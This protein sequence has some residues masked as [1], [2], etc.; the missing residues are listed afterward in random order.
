M[1][2]S[3]GERI[4]DTFQFCHL[5]IPV[6]SITATDRIL[7]AM[8]RLTAAIEGIQEAPHDELAAIQTL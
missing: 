1:A 7:D 4:T 5:A 3:G 2:N 8:A 6:P